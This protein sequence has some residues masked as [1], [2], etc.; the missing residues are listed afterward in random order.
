MIIYWFANSV[1][2]STEWIKGSQLNPPSAH[3]F[4]SWVAKSTYISTGE[5]NS[6]KVEFQRSLNA[7]KLSYL[8]NASFLNFNNTY[9]GPFHIRPFALIITSPMSRVTA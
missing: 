3:F 4:V 8:Y 1:V 7:V 2:A 5:R 6:K 9:N